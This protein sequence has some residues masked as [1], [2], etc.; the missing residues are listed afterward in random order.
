MPVVVQLDSPNCFI[1]GGIHMSLT[2]SGIGT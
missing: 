1:C 2:W